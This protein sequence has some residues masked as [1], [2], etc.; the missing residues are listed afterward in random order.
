[1]IVFWEVYIIVFF[2]FVLGH[3][4]FVNVN[5]FIFILT[6]CW[7]YLTVAILCLCPETVVTPFSH[8]YVMLELRKCYLRHDWIAATKLLLMLLD[9][10]SVLLKKVML[11]VCMD[12]FQSNFSL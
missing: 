10:G 4:H 6:Y 12:V 8:T 9:G 1:M 11:K 7:N 3:W 5:S 2:I